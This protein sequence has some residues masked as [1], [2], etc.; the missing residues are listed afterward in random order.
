MFDLTALCGADSRGKSGVVEQ[1]GEYLFRALQ[2]DLV[3]AR[4]MMERRICH[5][6]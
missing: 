2:T 1:D 5:E 3:I 6:H 4:H